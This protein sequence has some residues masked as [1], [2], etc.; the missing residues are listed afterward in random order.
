MNKSIHATCSACGAAREVPAWSLV[1]VR[2]EP[3]LKEKVRDGSLF[4][5]ECPHCGRTNLARYPL[6]YHDP[7][8]RL[9]VWMMPDGV[10]PPAQMDL[11]EKQLTTQEDALEGYTL[12]RVEDVGSLMEKVAVADAGLDDRVVELCKY[13]M[14]ME[15][16]GKPS[17]NLPPEGAVL[18]FYRMEGADNDLVFT[19]PAD[20][21]I[22][23]LRCGFNVYEDCAGIL[24]R[25]PEMTAGGGFA[26][27]D[28]DWTAKYFK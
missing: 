8:A 14:R 23:G 3:Q 1:N 28:A 9:M 16:D 10:L 13:V 24:R 27:I 21:R 18:R 20:G 2:E 22:Q 11:L 19:Y 25:N 17:G 26:R 12:R 4:L 5:W 15:E 6:V 7:D